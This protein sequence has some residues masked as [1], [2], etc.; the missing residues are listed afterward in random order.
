MPTA[1]ADGSTGPWDCNGTFDIYYGAFDLDG[2]EWKKSWLLY[3]MYIMSEYMTTNVLVRPQLEAYRVHANNLERQTSTRFLFLQNI[4]KDVMQGE[5]IQDTQREHYT[6]VF[7]SI[8]NMFTNAKLNEA[9]RACSLELR[10]V[11]QCISQKTTE[12][13]NTTKFHDSSVQYIEEMNTDPDLQDTGH[14]KEAA[15][16]QENAN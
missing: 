1:F 3:R 4:G 2:K 14:D 11:Y 16:Q 7:K 10:E 13:D 5:S 9:S 8:T 15:T 12:K 6:N